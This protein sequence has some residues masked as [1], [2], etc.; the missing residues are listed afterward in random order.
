M[1]HFVTP[2]LALALPTVPGPVTWVFAVT[3]LVAVFSAINVVAQQNP[4]HSALFLIANFFCIAVYYL[5]LSAQFLAVVQVIVYAGAIMVLF[6]FVL[7]L[8]GV[9]SEDVLQESIRGQR[10]A[11]VALGLLLLAA[12][13]AALLSGAFSGGG[14]GSLAAAN[15]GGNVQAVGRLLF[16]R[17]VFA[18]EATGLLLVV[19]AV[20]ALVLGKRRP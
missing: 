14:Q 18:F 16:T 17:Y 10:P 15:A 9:G 7:M 13:G 4:V 2:N 6:L 20:G 12:I 5:L 19:A 3:T 8:L 11:A 1:M